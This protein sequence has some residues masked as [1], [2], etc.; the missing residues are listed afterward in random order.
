MSTTPE[1]V[2]RLYRKASA[3]PTRKPTKANAEK[4]R[5]IA[6]LKA[7]VTRP[8]L[9]D[10]LLG[11]GFHAQAALPPA[12]I[13]NRAERIIEHHADGWTIPADSLGRP[14]T[15]NPADSILLWI[16]K[17]VP[18]VDPSEVSIVVEPAKR[19]KV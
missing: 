17:N 3:T 15:A 9:L 10:H 5:N 19:P 18:T 6:A 16:K 13:D 8:A 4:V 12:V 11:G 1:N 14:G 7:R 2:V